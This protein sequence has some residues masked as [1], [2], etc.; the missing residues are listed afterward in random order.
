MWSNSPDVMIME[1]QDS[2]ISDRYISW[3][4]NKQHMKFSEQRFLNHSKRTA[5]DYLANFDNCENKYYAIK[6]GSDL[7]G[8]GT[9][10][11]NKAY[12]TCSAGI[13][14]GP[15]FSGKGYGKQAWQLLTT[16]IP[17]SLGLRKVSAGTLETN[18]AMLRIFIESKMQFEARLVQEGIFE[19]SV[20]DVLLYRRIL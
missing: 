8:T 5:K 14:I 17:K 9:L 18:T 15:E 6:S 13:L 3:L 11:V 2:D 20:V 19:D 12:G 7:I 10:Y 4:N 16:I 1:F